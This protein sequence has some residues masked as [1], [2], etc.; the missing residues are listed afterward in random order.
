MLLVFNFSSDDAVP[1]TFDPRRAFDMA[2]ENNDLV[3]SKSEFNKYIT[4]FD[5]DSKPQYNTLPY[6]INYAPATPP[7]VFS[8]FYCFSYTHEI[9]KF[10]LYLKSHYWQNMCKYSNLVLIIQSSQKLFLKKSKLCINTD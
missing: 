6:L 1:P 2:N 3:V 8:L 7:L 4:S 5:D 10:N 9:L